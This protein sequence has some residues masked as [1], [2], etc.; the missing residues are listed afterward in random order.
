MNLLFG[1]T[2]SKHL[3]KYEKDLIEIKK[4]ESQYRETITSIEHVQSKTHEF[5]TRFI[6]LNVDDNDDL[7]EIKKRLNDT[8]HEAFALHRR[9]CEL[10]YGQKFDIGNGVEIEWTMIP[11]DV[12]LIG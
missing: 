6:G 5:Q 2:N 12:Q 9:A 8:K 3:R 10:I 7:I 4:I 1:D 11:Y